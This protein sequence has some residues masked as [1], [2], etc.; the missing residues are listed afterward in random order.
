MTTQK[1]TKYVVILNFEKGEVD[2]MM[3]LDDKP[4]DMDSQEW[5]ESTFNYSLSNCEWMITTNPFPN[6]LNF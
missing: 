6:P 3:L 4:E 1:K 5:I 2:V